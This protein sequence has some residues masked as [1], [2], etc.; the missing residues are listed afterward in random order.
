MNKGERFKVSRKFVVVIT[1][2]III[3]LIA[4]VASYR[5][6]DLISA[7]KNNGAIVDIEV[8]SLGDQQ[9]VPIGMGVSGTE[10]ESVPM[11]FKVQ[12]KESLSDKKLQYE[13][14]SIEDEEGNLCTRFFNIT[15][16]KVEDQGNLKVL[17]FDLGLILPDSKEEYDYIAGKSVTMTIRFWL[18]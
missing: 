4:I 10:S 15:N 17:S 16:D 12:G 6:P 9:L 13:V 11:V 8:S 1:T 14:V 18:E 7:S 2:I 3:L 5:I